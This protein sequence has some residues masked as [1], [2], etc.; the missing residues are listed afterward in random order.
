MVRRVRPGLQF[1]VLASC[2]P[3]LCLLAAGCQDRDGVRSYTVPRTSAADKPA[4]EAG[5]YRILGALFPADQPAWFF[6]LAGPADQL[7]KA[8]AAFDKIVGS[9]RFPNGLRNAPS[10]DVPDGCTLGGPR[11]GVVRIHETVRFGNGGPEMTVTASGGGPF[12][13]LKRRADQLGVP[14]TEA[15]LPR[16][17]RP[18]SAE[19]IEGLRVDFR[20]SKN[21]AARGMGGPMMKGR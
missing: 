8:E 7:D 2:L 19:K 16:H 1:A 18:F 20:G 15:D 4:A 3:S 10:F 6:K 21:P 12:A 17:T 13:N 14:L 9:V 11:E 5:E